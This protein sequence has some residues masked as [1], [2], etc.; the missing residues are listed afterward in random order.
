[1]ATVGPGKTERREPCLLAPIGR[2]VNSVSCGMVAIVEAVNL[3]AGEPPSA[4]FSFGVATGEIIGLL[5]PPG[6][7]RTPILRVLAGLDASVA[8]EVRLPGRGRIAI[9]TTGQQLADALSMQPDLVLVDAANDAADHNMWARLAG[10]RTLGTSFVVAT[11]NID[12]ACRGDRVSLASWDMYELTCATTELVRQMASQTQEF[13]AVLEEAKHRRNGS[14]AADLRRLNVASRALLAEMRRRARAGDETVA[15]HTAAWRV[16][17]VSVND[18][19]LDAS[20][21]EAQGR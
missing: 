16:A 6:K 13:L 11:S 3:V 2:R 18:R 15:W 1:V 19:V 9:A 20:I 12:Q 10:E 17:G 21:A 7:P 14:L 5:F 4:P 8:G